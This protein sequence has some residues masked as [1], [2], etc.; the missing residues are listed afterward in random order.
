MILL[1]GKRMTSRKSTHL[2]LKRK[3][4]LPSYYG[5]NLDALWDILSTSSDPMDIVL[6]NKDALNDNLGSYS[7]GLLSV[8]KD[9]SEDN[10]NVKF[11]IARIRL[12]KE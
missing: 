3:L 11:R 9:V 12:G 7:S 6:F 1:N 10:K 8:F 2:Y 4:N 5:N